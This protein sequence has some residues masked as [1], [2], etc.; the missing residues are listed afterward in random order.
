MPETCPPPADLI[1]AA[2]GSP[3]EPADPSV[4]EHVRDCPHCRATQAN[5]QEIVALLRTAAPHRASGG[6]CLD[7]Y[8]HARLVESA[9]A[10]ADHRVI[11]HLASCA[12]CRWQFAASLRLVRDPM[13]VG[14]LGRLESRAGS[15]SVRRSRLALAGGLAAAAVL[16]GLLL[17]PEAVRLLQR[18]PGPADTYRERT[19]TT[20]APPRIVAPVGAAT[21]TDSLVWTSV[22]GADLYRVTFWRPDG[23]VAWEGE[24]LDTALVIPATLSSSGG[25]PLMWQ[26]KARTGWDRWVGS[27]LAQTSLTSP[28][29]SSR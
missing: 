1:L 17:S 24:S 27:D 15:P 29:R 28:R 26:V 11:E 9:G 5:L 16:A 6:E 7:A 22:P 8:E 2:L 3:N 10:A 25:G 13:I 19:I 18:D 14:E 21:T 23:T 12:E 4:V 20:T